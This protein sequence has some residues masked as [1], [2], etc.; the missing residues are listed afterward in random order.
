VSPVA[1]VLDASAVLA[2]AD[3]RVAVGELI[4]MV[5]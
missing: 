5:W 3:G 1:V 2:Y 4:A